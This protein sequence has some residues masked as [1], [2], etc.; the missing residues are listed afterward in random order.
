MIAVCGWAVREAVTS[1]GVKRDDTRDGVVPISGEVEHVGH[2]AAE[3]GLAR[4]DRAEMAGLVDTILSNTPIGIGFLDRE[5]R[6]RR[7]NPTLAAVIGVTV[8]E[9]IGQTI[10]AL[11]PE[12]W[13][14]L[15]PLYRQVLDTG[16]ATRDV[17]MDGP[18]EAD[19]DPTRIHHWL[20]SFYPVFVDG[21][22]IGISNVVFDISA[23]ADAEDARLRLAR[24]VEDS[25]EAM[26]SSTADGIATSWN[27]AAER[28]FG[29]TA[30]EFIGQPVALLAP[31]ELLDEQ[32]QMRARMAVGA[33]TERH[34]T[35]RQRKDGTRV[36]VLI[37]ASPSIDKAGKVIGASVIAQ[38]IGERR[39]AQRELWA[40]E[41]RLEEAQRIAEIGSFEF[42]VLTGALIWSAEHYRILG[43][44]P[45][46]TP[47]AELFFALVHPDD[48]TRA[49][50]AWH[51][52]TEQGDASD[53][54]FRIIR[55]DSE[56]RWV[57]SRSLPEVAADGA[58]IKVAGTL[59]DSTE[60]VEAARSRR[61]ADARF[62]AGFEQGGVGAGILGLDGIPVRVNAA[63]CAI[64]GRP[65][66]LLVNR[67]WDDYQHP[68]NASL[69]KAMRRQLTAGHDTYTDERRFLRPDGTIV[70]TSV[71]LTLV[72]DEA[73]QP[74]Y[75][76][77]QLEDISERKLMAE[78]LAFQATHDTLTGLANSV[79]LTDCLTRLLS[80]PDVGRSRV[81]VIFVDVD[82]LKLV[83]ASFGHAAGDALLDQVAHRI[84]ATIRATDIVARFRGDEFVIVCADVSMQDIEA[85]AERLRAALRRS[86][87]IGGREIT[88]T[89][90]LGI[91]VADTGSTPESLL[92]DSDHAM[93]EAKS[94]G[95]DRIKMFDQT[96]RAKTERRL[97]TATALRRALERK[98]LTVHYQPVV[99]LATG[100]MVS[101]EALLRWNHPGRGSISPV[102]FIPIAEETGLIIPI[103]AWVLEQACD[104]LRRWQRTVPSMTVAVN[105]SV[106]Q[107]LAPDILTQI[108]DIV[109]RSKIRPR[110]LILELTESV[111]MQD[112]DYFGEMLNGLKR[113]DIQLSLDDFGTGYSS[114]S[115]LRRFSF[116]I[117]KIDRA[118]VRSLGINSNDTALVA[119]ILSM[120][121]ALGLS[122]VAEGIEDET[123]LAALRR[124]RCPRAQGFYFDR[125]MPAEAIYHLITAR[126]RW[127]IEDPPA[128]ATRDADVHLAVRGPS[129]VAQILL[130]SAR[131]LLRVTSAEQAVGTLM[132]AV[133]EL[134]GT[135]VPA[136]QA[137]ATAIPMDI[138]LGQAAPLLP[139]APPGSAAR[140]D[141]EH[142]LPALVED[143]RAAADNASRISRMSEQIDTD[144][145]TGLGNRRGLRRLRKLVRRDTVVMLDL[146]HFK[147]VNDSEGHDAGDRLLVAFSRMLRQRLRSTDL[148]FRLGGEEFL[149]VLPDTGTDHALVLLEQ[150]RLKWNLE[151]PLAVTFSAG[152][153]RIDN[154]DLETA[155]RSADGALYTAKSRGRNRFEIVT[156]SPDASTAK[157]DTGGQGSG[158]TTS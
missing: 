66:E 63:A 85:R 92:R 35:V 108:E 33:S 155:M 135:C 153:A 56:L 58:V 5:L 143:A 1:D 41:R 73:G 78:K 21:E 27:G 14:Q 23:R 128:T 83:N 103:G 111:F 42:D 52:V 71:H 25:G 61:D 26:F 95:R 90:S 154:G 46:V 102:E 115:Y 50:Q 75:Y 55:P 17:A 118:F 119:A 93:W 126:H 48:R 97:T 79:L 112:I 19:E 59:R 122:V 151:R 8:E 105:L 20:S 157:S 123:Q 134:G 94:R 127:P 39:S 158:R 81:G 133:A 44:D 64:L 132:S 148:V 116:D 51:Q 149:L 146:D 130:D 84:T 53:M 76:L 54:M 104:Q 109:T 72:R 7:M 28:L 156:P 31:P 10:D 6:V 100:E 4:R 152:I 82:Q 60:R 140:R 57:H 49:A 77:G 9:S 121:E 3:L 22:V 117:V 89:A 96:L 24:I 69:Y 70:W 98:E 131:S 147:K 113:L 139:M 67:S 36:E 129:E 16:Q 87:R 150:M 124:M 120:G 141:I 88:V 47:T 106:R 144:P 86:Y 145:L 101:A 107:V 38:D 43:L 114:L 65:Q 32:E 68:D 80:G 12:I 29:Y 34:E 2:L 91:A 40:S 137:P 45:A 18:S 30:D 11:V 136:A 62:E 142:V 37:T 138:S 13:P 99:D 74:Q 15:E 110:S 125:P